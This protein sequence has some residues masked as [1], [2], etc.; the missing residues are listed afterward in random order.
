L[1]QIGSNEAVFDGRGHSNGHTLIIATTTFLGNSIEIVV[2]WIAD[3][4]V[5]AAISD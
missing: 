2:L 1:A 3:S 5:V 4:S